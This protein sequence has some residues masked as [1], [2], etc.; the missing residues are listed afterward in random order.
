M[1]VQL[2]IKQFMRNNRSALIS[3]AAGKIN[4][5]VGTKKEKE[6]KKKWQKQG[7]CGVIDFCFS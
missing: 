4:Q 3:S 7:V 6:D 2:S 5:K 1:Q